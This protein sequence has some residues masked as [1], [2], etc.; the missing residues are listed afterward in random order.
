MVGILQPLYSL[1]SVILSP[2]LNVGSPIEGAMLT[3]ACLSL[4]L[5]LLFSFMYKLLMDQER[6]KELKDKMNDYKQEMKEE[7]EKGNQDKANKL[8]QKSMKLNSKFFKM[9]IKPMLASMVIVF[10][11]LPWM[12]SQF[13]ANSRLSQ[14]NGEFVGNFSYC[15]TTVNIR[16]TNASQP[17]EFEDH[18]QAAAG[19]YITIEKSDWEVMKVKQTKQDEKESLQVKL[20]LSFIKLPVGIPLA[21]KSLG[22]LGFYII[23]SLPSTYL[24]RK[25]LGVH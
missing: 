5:S 9:S 14:Q 15:G 8:M 1:Y 19:E 16:G 21:G 7:R 17:L 2:L 3:V 23:I 10:L 25:L 4:L 12:S 6:A 18:G 11:I 20:E 22:W 13:S 24:F